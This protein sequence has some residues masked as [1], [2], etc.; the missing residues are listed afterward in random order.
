M[1]SQKRKLCFLF[2]TSLR[3]FTLTSYPPILEGKSK[4]SLLYQGYVLSSFK[5]SMNSEKQLES[6]HSGT[7][8]ISSSSPSSKNTTAIFRQKL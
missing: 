6:I 8:S 1:A 2:K 3:G 5:V 4:S 7:V